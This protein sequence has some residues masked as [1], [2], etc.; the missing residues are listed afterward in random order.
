MNGS[1]FAIPWSA[2]LRVGR[3]SNNCGRILLQKRTY[4][5]EP[6]RPSPLH[7]L[8]KENKSLSS[9]WPASCFRRAIPSLCVSIFSGCSQL[10]GAFERGW[11]AIV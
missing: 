2:A 5:S 10:G 11:V 1:N 7:T 3:C 4:I 8:K 6:H 9:L